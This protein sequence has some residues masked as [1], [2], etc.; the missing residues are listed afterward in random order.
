MVQQIPV[1]EIIEQEGVIHGL[2]VLDKTAKEVLPI[3]FTKNQ[4]L[5]MVGKMQTKNEPFYTFS[6]YCQYVVYTQF[7]PVLAFT[8]KISDYSNN[9]DIALD[10][11]SVLKNKGWLQSDR[12]N[13]MKVFQNIKDN[14]NEKA[15]MVISDPVR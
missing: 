2:V 11:Y 12:D 1:N 15:E 9:L 4:L 13:I 3:I 6:R 10:E 7:D 5:G 8:I 14:P